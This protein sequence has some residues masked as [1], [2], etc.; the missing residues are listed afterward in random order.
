[1][2]RATIATILAGGLAVLGAAACEERAGDGPPETLVS[3]EDEVEPLDSALVS[4]LPPGAT[5]ETAEEGRRLF[6]VCSVCHGLDAAG[7]ALGPALN[8]GE[9]IA[10]S[11]EPEEI[12]AVIRAGVPA[13]EEFP[14]PMPVMGGGDFTDEEVRAL[15]VYVYVLGRA[16]P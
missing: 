1:M 3:A 10:G 9:W 13:P 7:T 16:T 14:I 6:V 11:G 2:R 15:A 5:L 4:R 8:D 12:E